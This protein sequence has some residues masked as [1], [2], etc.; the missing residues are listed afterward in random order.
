MKRA[1]LAWFA[2]AAL[3][4]ACASAPTTPAPTA[5]EATALPTPS[6]APTAQNVEP[7]ATAKTTPEVSKRL[8]AVATF[9]VIADWLQNVAGDRVEVFTLAGAEVEPHDYEPTPQ[10]SVRLAEADLVF[11][12]GAGFETWLDRLFTASGSRAQR[13]VLSE[14]LTLRPFAHEHEH[15]GGEHKEG[16]HEHKEGEHGHGEL[17]PHVWQ[18]PLNVVRIVER[19]AE[20]LKAADPAGAET[21]ARNA[22]RY[23]EQLRA[24]DAEIEQLVARIPEER[25]KIATSH[26]A[27]GYFA[28]RYGFEIIRVFVAPSEANQP[29][30]QSIAEVVARLREEK[31]TVIF[32]ESVGDAP[33]LES[34][35]REIGAKIGPPLFTDAL[36]AAG[37]PGSTYLDAMRYN[38][39]TLVDAL[40]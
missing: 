23:A 31:V 9:S 39:R 3:V 17:D 32:G 27:L 2:V 30:A 38:A 35:A 14:G 37:K 33:A 26:E 34:I 29:S 13:V 12:I 7:T 28:D 16:D 40:Q 15:E 21:Y 22:A 36:F 20:A 19:M 6:P 10:D 11:E 24:L 8:K 25:R 18:N 1:W 5:A 4:S